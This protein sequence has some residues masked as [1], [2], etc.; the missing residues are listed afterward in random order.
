MT[1]HF[2]RPSEPVTDTD[3]RGHA[4]VQYGKA[5]VLTQRVIPSTMPRALHAMAPNLF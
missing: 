1:E 2:G 3:P 4:H 5:V